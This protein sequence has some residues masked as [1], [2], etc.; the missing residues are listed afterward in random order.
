MKIEEYFIRG[1]ICNRCLKVL[2]E[3]LSAI[4]VE[5]KDIR[6]G[7]VQISYNSQE[8]NYPKIEKILREN[9]FEILKDK[10]SVLAEQTKKWIIK[11]IWETE[12]VENL[13]DF[14]HKQMNENYQVLSRS[15]SKIFGQTIERYYIQL[16]IERVK[17]LIE[18]EELSFSEIA[19]SIGYQNT[20]ALSRQF[21]RETGMTMKAYQELE[22]SE[23]I[24]LDEI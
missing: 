9:E 21:K 6:L 3:E 2:K 14:L 23:R 11:F 22:T 8:I 12:H 24:P 15:F 4:G 16:K 13:S 7:R 19:Y 20:S 1:M 18:Y 10:E 5:V 17:E